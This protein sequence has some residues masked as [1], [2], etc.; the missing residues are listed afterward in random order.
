[1]S[2]FELYVHHTLLPDRVAN[3]L[4]SIP[5]EFVGFD[6]DSVV[7]VWARVKIR[8][9]KNNSFRI[10]TATAARAEIAGDSSHGVA[11]EWAV[12]IRLLEQKD[13]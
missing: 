12:Q 10:R 5:L 11:G 9:I 4:L 3:I 6:Q 1:V 13:C 8:W 7:V 2:C